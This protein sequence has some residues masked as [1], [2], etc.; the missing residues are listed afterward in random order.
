[1]PIL[2]VEDEAA[3]AESV[4]AA[5]E[6]ERLD[7]V[8][9]ETLAE[10][11]ELL[12]AR[13]ITL[14]ILDVGLPDGSGFDLCREIRARGEHPPIVFLTARSEVTDRVLGLELGGDDYLPKPFSPREL[15]ARVRAVL[16]RAQ[17]PGPENGQGDSVRAGAVATASG[18][19][20]R[21]TPLRHDPT[22]CRIEAR[23]RALE[24]SRNE[25]RLLG[26]L[27]QH[28][29]RVFSRGQLLEGVWEDP[30]ASGERTVDAHI[31]SLRAKLREALGE[32]E[33]IL[34]HRGLGYSLAE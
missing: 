17:G 28:P 14:A 30:W 21:S 5:L 23:G 10:A 4:L 24:L 29:G 19:P 7:A 34:T 27:M 22:R 25:Y 3:I 12:D 15:V 26:Y 2:V 8:H 32:E 6:M 1:M 9:A 16:R 18:R 11:R 31:K 33:V 20:G 13:D